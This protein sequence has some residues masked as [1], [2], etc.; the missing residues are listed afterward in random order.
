MFTSVSA[1]YQKAKSWHPEIPLML[2]SRRIIHSYLLSLSS[3]GEEKS[4]ESS[5][6]DENTNGTHHDS[7]RSMANRRD[8]NSKAKMRLNFF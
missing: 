2:I 3:N 5:K 1:S 4:E 8:G 7:Q 6:G